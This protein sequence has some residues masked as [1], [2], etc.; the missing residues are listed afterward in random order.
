[1]PILPKEPDRFPLNLLESDV[2]SS[3]AWWLLYTKSR[4]EKQLMRQLREIEVAHYGPQIEQRRRSPAGRVRTSYVPLFANYIF[5]CGSDESRYKAVCTGCVQKVT[6]IT[7][8]DMLLTDLSQVSDLINIGAPMSIE[9]RISP[10]QQVRVKNG[11]FAGFE[12]VVIRRDQ[13]TRLLVSVRFM[14]QGVSVKLDDCQLDPI[15]PAPDETAT[16]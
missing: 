1:M 7:D 11:P 2:A 5:L 10:G 6:E 3:S 4:Q 9:E 15:G 8:V 12:G 13:E 14:D 16:S